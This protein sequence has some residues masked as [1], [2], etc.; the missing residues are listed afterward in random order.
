MALDELETAI[1]LDRNFALAYGEVGIT[2]IQLG[3]SE[4]AFVPLETAIRLSPRDPQLNIWYYRICHAHE[5]LAHDAEAIEW[6]RKSVAIAPF[7]FAYVNLA[8][9]YAYMGQQAEARAAVAEL[10]RL[11]PGFTV[12]RWASTP[13]SNNPLWLK[14]YARITEGLRKAGLP[15]K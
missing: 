14:Q 1:A 3:R 11:Q 8:A 12:H 13:Y 10:L 9:S 7:W 2:K 5:H 15:E 4:E 6:C